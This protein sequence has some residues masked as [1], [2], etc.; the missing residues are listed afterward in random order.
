MA[1]C[2]Q[3]MS[4][5]WPQVVDPIELILEFSLLRTIT[6]W[7]SGRACHLSPSIR[8]GGRVFIESVTGVVK[9]SDGIPRGD[10]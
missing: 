7:P 6:R 1:R 9:E 8:R 10:G 4:G 3:K 5:I 2:I